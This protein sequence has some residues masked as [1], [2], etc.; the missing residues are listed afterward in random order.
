MVQHPEHNQAARTG[1]RRGRRRAIRRLGTVATLAVLAAVTACVPGG[2]ASGSGSGSGSDLTIGVGSA[3]VSYGAFWVAEANNLF[4]KNGVKVKVASYNTS[5]QTANLLASGQIQLAVFGANAVFQL[6][7]RGKKAWMLDELSTFNPGTTVVISNKGITSA[8]Q[9]RSNPNCR[10]ATTQVGTLP[11]AYTVRYQKAE[12]LGNCKLIL[13]AGGPPLLAAVSSGSVQAGVVTYANAL[14]AL[15]AGK[16]KRLVD[17]LN[18]PAALAQKVAPHQYPSFGIV[19]LQS[20]V[21]ENSQAVIRFLRAIRQANTLLLKSS[22]S[23]LGQESAKLSAFSGASPVLL[24]DAWK[25]VLGGIPTGPQAGYISQSQWQQ[26]LE[27][28]VDWQIPGYDRNDPSNSYGDAVN[29]SYFNK[30]K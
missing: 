22:P 28:Y 21:Q 11:Y 16:V 27:G 25:A 18:V 14:A 6:N 26:T 12:N 23:Q 1:F 17:P 7:P 15:N 29:M 9:L 5:G 8:D 19:G 30:A 24:A 20:T 4:A 2:G 13:E 10:I 3:T